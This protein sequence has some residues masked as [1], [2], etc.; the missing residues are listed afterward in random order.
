MTNEADIW[1]SIEQEQK[2]YCD[3]ALSE[4]KDYDKFYLY[5]IIAHSTALEG[6]TLSE[7]DA[8]LLFDEGITGKGNI[9]E[10][11][12]NID[13]RAAYEYAVA[14]A[15][16]KTT[17]TPALLKDLN[18]LVMKNTGGINNMPAGTFDSGRGEYRLCG[19]SAGIG[20]KSYMDYKKVPGNVNRLCEEL[21]KRMDAESLRDKYNLSF[22]AHFNLVTIHPW[23]D[24]NGRT[25]RLLMNYI[26]FYHELT[27]TRIR[28]EDKGGYIKALEE[29]RGRNSN[30]PF[31]TFMARQHLKTLREEIS[32]HT[33]RRNESDNFTALF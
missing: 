14:E 3:L 8:S 1:L 17:I 5:S 26:Q 28:K 20:G 7:Q 18:A 25:S 6:S 4:M 30:A 29:S 12:M 33:R 32:N 21:D 11:L 24:G 19:V 31:R 27:P 16:R 10:Y 9:V 22:D 23:L 15:H 2:R 13:L